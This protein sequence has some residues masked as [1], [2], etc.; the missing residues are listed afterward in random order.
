MIKGLE[1]EMKTAAQ[2]LEFERAAQLRDEVKE[3]RE[4]LSLRE[5]GITQNTPA[6]EKVRKMDE[7]EM[8]YDA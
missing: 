4:V 1:Q 2:Q 7:A 8:P 3:L 5:A 6:W